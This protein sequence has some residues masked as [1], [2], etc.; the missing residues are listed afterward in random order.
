MVC[1]D[2]TYGWFRSIWSDGCE[3]GES[4]QQVTERLDRLIKK[5]RDIQRP[6]MD[7]SKAADVVVVGWRDREF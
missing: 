4:P 2:F 7:G 1:G 3:D 6:S 5:I